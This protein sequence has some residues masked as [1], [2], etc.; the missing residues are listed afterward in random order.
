MAK[1]RNGAKSP[2]ISIPWLREI[3]EWEDAN[4]ASRHYRCEREGKEVYIDQTAAIAV[5]TMHFM[6][7]EADGSECFPGERYLKKKCRI[8]ADTVVFLRA[9]WREHGW[10]HDTGHRKQGGGVVYQLTIAGS[11]EL[12]PARGSLR[13]DPR[14][15]TTS[16]K[17]KPGTDPGSDPVT[18]PEVISVPGSNLRTYSETE[19]RPNPRR[20]GAGRAQYSAPSRSQ[21]PPPTNGHVASRAWEAFRARSRGREA[22]ARAQRTT[23][24][25]EDVEDEWHADPRAEL[26]PRALAEAERSGQ[27]TPLGVLALH[28]KLFGETQGDEYVPR[29]GWADERRIAELVVQ[30]YGERARWLVQAMHSGKVRLKDTSLSFL[31]RPA[32]LGNGVGRIADCLKRV[33]DVTVSNAELLP[34]IQA[35]LAECEETGK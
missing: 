19:E 5:A 17:A 1:E 24:A 34:R 20:E 6:C 2:A 22:S 12:V 25:T 33:R 32:N 13:T 26:L 18:D 8:R 3:I 27:W 4:H 16:G 9:R 31:L 14:T 7:A 21:T 10:L 30:Q 29:K 23:F 35:A 28:A 15:G 11:G